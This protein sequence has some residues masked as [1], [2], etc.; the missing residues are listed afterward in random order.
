MTGCAKESRQLSDLLRG[1]RRRQPT[2]SVSFYLRE[3]ML[4]R[5]LTIAL[6]LSVCLSVTSRSSIETDERIELVLAL[7]LPSIRPALC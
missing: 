4:A 1:S 7:E 6:C 3:A 2:T 5:I